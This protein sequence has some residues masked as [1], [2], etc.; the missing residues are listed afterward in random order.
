MKQR[1]LLM[2]SHLNCLLPLFSD[3]YHNRLFYFFTASYLVSLIDLQGTPVAC[4]FLRRIFNDCYEEVLAEREG[5]SSMLLER[6]KQL[7][8]EA[9]ILIRASANMDSFWGVATTPQYGYDRISSMPTAVHLA[10]RAHMTMEELLSTPDL[11]QKE[12]ER[13]SRP[14]TSA[15]TQ[16]CSTIVPVEIG[17]PIPILVSRIDSNPLSESSLDIVEPG[18][19]LLFANSISKNFKIA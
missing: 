12:P 9:P 10:D 6:V 19:K 1:S 13:Q 3:C 11:T 5:R 2:V 4:K 8:E 14:T 15:A 16:V 7:I 18:M 17:Q